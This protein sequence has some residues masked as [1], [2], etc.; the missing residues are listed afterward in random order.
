MELSDA[1]EK[2]I[3]GMGKNALLKP[4]LIGHL[5]EVKD[6]CLREYTENEIKE[7]FK[8]EGRQEGLEEARIESIRKMV[9]KL[10]ITKEEAMDV[11]EVP[12][13]ER[14]ALKKVI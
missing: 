14:E 2:A 8:E 11:L 5:A 1:I 4:F 12:E 10:G 3:R 7:M 9:E 13:A 6:M